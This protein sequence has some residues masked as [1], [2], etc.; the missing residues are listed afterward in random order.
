MSDQK[1]EFINE[2]DPNSNDQI[3]VYTASKIRHA[4]LL[5]DL[6]SKHVRIH[7]TA[8][9]IVTAPLSSEASRPAAQWLHD[10]F[11]DITRSHYVLSYIEHGEQLKTA[12]GEIFYGLAHGLHVWLVTGKPVNATDEMFGD[13]PDYQPWAMGSRLIHRAYS[14]EQALNEIIS[15]WTH[16]RDRR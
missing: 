8:R 7:F 13:H 12:L 6:R 2:Y 9:W 11:D 14:N 1:V 10:N 15:H 4:G 16:R 3:K 5:R